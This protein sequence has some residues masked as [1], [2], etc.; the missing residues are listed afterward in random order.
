MTTAFEHSVMEDRVLRWMEL[1]FGQVSADRRSFKINFPLFSA[2]CR[3]Y[4]GIRTSVFIPACAVL[5]VDLVS[6]NLG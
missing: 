3:P 2:F 4:E 1:L 6:V 5:L